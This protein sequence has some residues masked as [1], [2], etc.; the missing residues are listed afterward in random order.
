M[1]KQDWDVPG[2]L[3]NR[4]YAVFLTGVE[5]ED[6]ADMLFIP[7]KHFVPVMAMWESWEKERSE[8]TEFSPFAEDVPHEFP[9]ID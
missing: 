6:A 9:D 2:S 1:E 4:L 5:F 8:E 3:M 7:S